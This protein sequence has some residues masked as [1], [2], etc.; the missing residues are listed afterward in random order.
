MSTTRATASIADT[1]TT[2]ATGRSGLCI[3]GTSRA[4]RWSSGGTWPRGTLR[5][6]RLRNEQRRNERA[7]RE[8]ERQ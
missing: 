6:R 1:G 8:G 4:R 7:Q 3:L 2:K 5:G